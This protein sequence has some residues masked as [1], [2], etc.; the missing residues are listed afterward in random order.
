M[1]VQNEGV[2]NGAATPLQENQDLTHMLNIQ[3]SRYCLAL[4]CTVSSSQPTVVKG[5]ESVHI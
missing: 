5:F 1:V 2:K 4:A 3:C